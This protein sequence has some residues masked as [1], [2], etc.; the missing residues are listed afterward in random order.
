MKWWYLVIVIFG[1]GIGW[2]FLSKYGVKNSTPVAVVKND[3]VSKEV[4][5][6]PVTVMPDNKGNK[7]NVN[8]IKGVVQNWYPETG[9]IEFIRDKKLWR[10]TIDPTES[11]VYIPSVSQK[12]RIYMISDN[13]HSH[14]K[15]A[16]CV[17]DEVDIRLAGEK[18]VAI[19]NGG[20]R[21]CGFKGE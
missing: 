8:Q 12:G 17:A 5:N 1:V 16:F 20:Y 21:A 19:S 3:I 7:V 11:I 14:W 4:I 9:V 6:L 18:V 13:N 10:L 2:W 15:T